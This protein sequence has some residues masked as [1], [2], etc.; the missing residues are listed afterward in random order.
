M[1]VAVLDE[2]FDGIKHV[3]NPALHDSSYFLISSFMKAKVGKASEAKAY[4]LLLVPEGKLSVLLQ[5][6]TSLFLDKVNRFFSAG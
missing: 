6:L 3:D 1:L 4:H 2:A 5:G